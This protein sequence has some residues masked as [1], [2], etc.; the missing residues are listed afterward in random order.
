MHRSAIGATTFR[1]M[2]TEVEVL[3]PHPQLDDALEV[4]A[5]L[6]DAWDRRFSRFQPDSELSSLNAAAGAPFAASEPMLGVV[7]ASLVAAR[8]TD[9]LFDPALL[10]RLVDLGYAVDFDELSPAATDPSPRAWQ[11]GRWRE[12]AVDRSAACITLPDGV[13]LDLGGI[14]KGMA[15]DAALGALAAAGIGPTAVNAGGDLGVRG[16]PH[17]GWP[18]S[19]D[20]AGRSVI[21]H[22][23]AL[24]TSSVLKRRW[25]TAEG[26]RH[27]LIDPRTGEPA[28]GVVVSASVAAPTCRAAEVAAKAALLL[29]PGD[30]AVWLA[31]HRLTGVLVLANGTSW[32][33]GEWREAA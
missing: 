13:A 5:T 12:I 22:H 29:G 8:L 2:G 15:V 24:A 11:P 26:E 9:G 1:S 20:D 33:L 25:Q 27:H 4:V 23:G 16:E 19:L 18:I 6:F 32:N 31:A 10:P 17:G 14:A 30:A 28:G 21:L 7:A 3:A